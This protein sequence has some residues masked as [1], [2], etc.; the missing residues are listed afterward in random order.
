[1]LFIDFE[2]NS[3]TQEKVNLVCCSILNSKNSKVENFWLLDNEKEKSR[4]NSYLTRHTDTL[5]SWSVVAESRSLYSLGLDPM[6]FNWLDLF[7][8]YKC[9]SNHSDKY[10]YGKQL[11]NGK[12]V[13][14]QKPKPKW[15][16]TEE[17]SATGFKPTHSLAE[18]TYKLTGKIRDTEHKN[19]MRDIIISNDKKLILENKKAIMDYCQ[20]DVVFLPELYKVM[21]EEYRDR[22]GYEY[23]KDEIVN[24]ALFRGKYAALTGIRESKGYPINVEH[25]KNFSDQVANILDECQRDINSQFPEISPFKWKKSENRFAWNQIKTKQWIRDRGLDEKWKKTDS[26]DLSLSLEA[27]TNEFDYKHDYPRGNFGAQMVRYLKLKQSLNGFRPKQKDTDKSFWDSVGEDGRVRPY[28]GIYNSQSSRSQPPSTS[29]LL[30]KPAWQRSLLQPA[31]GKCITSIDYGSEEYF[32]SALFYNDKKMIESYLSG[33]VYLAFAKESKMVPQNATKS[34]HKYERDLCKATVL[35][36]SYLMSK[37]GLSKKLTADTGKEWTPDQA[38]ELIDMFY[39]TYQDFAQGQ[40]DYLSDYEIG[41]WASLPDGWIMWGDNDNFRSVTNYPSQG[42]GASIMRNAD[43][44]CHRS[45]LYIPCTL[46]DA[47]YMEHD[48]G[49][50]EAIDKMKEAMIE[51]FARFFPENYDIAKQIRLDPF[52]WGPDLPRPTVKIDDKT[53]RKEKIYSTITTPGGLEVEVSDIYIDERAE[54]EYEKFSKY[55]EFREESVL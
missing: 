42:L 16:R 18:A 38:Q 29:Y 3:T 47:L 34:S 7:L 26:N 28:M 41:G 49:D 51:G 43:L 23:K 33:D 24:G 39:D 20:E 14:T 36:I 6:I 2:F 37:Y 9:L 21:F 45:G 19:K 54:S 44:R 48:Y 46:H 1:M 52:T 53:G 32:I 35:G 17:D 4:L 25:T 12:V 40:K 15:E 27:W 30:L 55:F 13:N 50:W 8:E 5:V 22:L 31:K 10:N 11:V